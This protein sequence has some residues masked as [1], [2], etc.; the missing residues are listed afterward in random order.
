MTRFK[1]VAHDD[2][3]NVKD[4]KTFNAETLTDVVDQFS[5]FQRGVGF[6]FDDLTVNVS[7]PWGEIEDSDYD[8]LVKDVAEDTTTN[9]YDNLVQFTKE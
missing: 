3:T 1:I 9:S 2:D 8:Q 5:D 6:V 7:S 4:V